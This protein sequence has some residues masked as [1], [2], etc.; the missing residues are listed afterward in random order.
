MTVGMVPVAT[1]HVDVDHGYS[2]PQLVGW[3]T[4]PKKITTT[5]VTVVHNPAHVQRANFL[6]ICSQYDARHPPQNADTCELLIFR[7]A[8][9][10]EKLVNLRSNDIDFIEPI[11]ERFA[12]FFME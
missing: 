7:K 12:I 1:K 2:I 10:G 11:L 4:N 5:D 6:I 8:I 3:F 9:L